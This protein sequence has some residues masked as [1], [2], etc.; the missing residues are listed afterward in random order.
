MQNVSYKRTVRDQ[1]KSVKCVC[2]PQEDGYCDPEQQEPDNKKADFLRPR[3]AACRRL[4]QEEDRADFQR[5]V[6]PVHVEPD[7]RLKGR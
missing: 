7:F 3:E 4:V 5:A 2:V 1:G 6:S